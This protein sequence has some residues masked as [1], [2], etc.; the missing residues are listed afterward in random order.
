MEFRENQMS[1]KQKKFKI[2]SAK[3]FVR[4]IHN[5][6]K[7]GKKKAPSLR[8]GLGNAR[9]LTDSVF[10][11]K[12]VEE[13]RATPLYLKLIAPTQFPQSLSEMRKGVPAIPREAMV[14]Q[15]MVTGSFFP[16]P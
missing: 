8:V 1:F 7:S 9:T 2:T 15:A 12:I 10:F 13:I 11:E 16:M 4:A 6:S 5:Y 14:K 3:Q